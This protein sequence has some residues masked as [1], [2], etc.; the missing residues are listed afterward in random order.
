MERRRFGRSGWEL[1]VIGLGTW[2]T[3]DVGPDGEAAAKE[4]VDTV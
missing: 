3:F 2:R 1:P 4:V